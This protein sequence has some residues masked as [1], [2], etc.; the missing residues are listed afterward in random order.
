MGGDYA[1]LEIV[2]GAVDAAKSGHDVVLVGDETQL[3]AILDRCDATLPMVHAGQVIEMHE[4]PA[5]AVREKKDASIM[6]G[7]RLVKEGEAG[8]LVSAGSTGAALAASAFVIGRL[9]GVSRP[10]I[11]SLFPTNE[12]VLDIGANLDVRPSHLVQFGVMGAALAEVFLGLEAP[13][14]GLL[15]IGEEA[16]KGRELERIAHDLFAAADGINFAGNVEGRDLGRDRADVFVTDGYTGNILLKTGEG[17]SR[18][19]YRLLL[20]ALQADE[21]QEALTQLM[22]AFMRLRQQIDPESVGGAHLV[23]TKGV[24]VIAHGASSH[25][26]AANAIALAAEG[27]DEGLT[28]RITDGIARA[29]G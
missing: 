12:V 7:A 28:D 3:S 17:T 20:E 27:G 19:L 15:N 24:V 26:A 10:A 8:A 18:A 22:P 6:V 25:R 14:V 4:D 11:A 5:R 1:P 2:R 29:P 9:P 16:G 13:R 23:G 21:Y